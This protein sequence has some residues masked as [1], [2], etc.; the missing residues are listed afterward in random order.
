MTSA[1]AVGDVGNRG[2]RTNER[3]VLVVGGTGGIGGAISRAF[4]RRGDRVIA[5]G[6]TD[7]EMRAAQ[8]NE[9][10]IGVEL[11]RLDVR[12]DHA[13]AALVGSLDRLDV[14]VNSAGIPAS[15]SDFTVEGFVRSLDVNLVGVARACFAARPLLAASRGCIVNV[16]SMMSFRGS[17]T[18]PAYAAAK[19]G[20]GQLT[21]SLAAAWGPSV[22]VNAVAPGWIR[23]P[24]TDHLQHDELVDARVVA[25]TPA[26]RWGE[27]DEVAVAALFLS[28]AT[29]TFVNGVMLPADGGYL[30]T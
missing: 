20:V 15:P 28:E 3:T 13:V 24:L 23:T 19:G 30:A 22:R 6:L 27:P 7:D 17:A 5:T 9:R 1:S 8:Q 18:G 26:K 10:L 11:R 12:D 2:S 21:K 16:G 25:R 4:A 14:L 29:S